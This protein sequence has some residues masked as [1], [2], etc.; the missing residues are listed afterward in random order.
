MPKRVISGGRD[1]IA[2]L[3]TPLGPL[4]VRADSCG[5]TGV[6]FVGR[7]E[8][9]PG[10]PAD[11]REA[12]PKVLRTALVELDEYFRG[13]RRSFSLPLV[14]EG[15]PFQRKVWAALLRIPYGRT[16]SYRE[17]AAA[18]GNARATR[19]VGGANH[20]NPISILVPCHRV[21]GSDGRLTGYGGGLWRKEW[22]LAHEKGHAAAGAPDLPE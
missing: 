15:T 21:V 6:D 9:N 16:L 20:R 10:R 18:V 2:Y 5:I 3:E 7:G 12:M 11:P 13:M 14:L 22:L 4:K 8:P 19:A 1:F 17:V